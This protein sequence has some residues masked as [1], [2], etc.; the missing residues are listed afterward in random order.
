M[1]YRAR[2]RYS[3]RVSRWVPI[4]L[5]AYLLVGCLHL[6]CYAD[7]GQ[8][9]AHSCCQQEDASDGSCCEKDIALLSQAVELNV[10]GAPLLFVLEPEPGAHQ[11]LVLERLA[12]RAIPPP[13]SAPQL[14]LA[15]PRAPPFQA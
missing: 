8:E 2:L 9:S 14:K 15:P 6:P 13:K 4:F 10:P 3:N 5:L 11:L 7:L 12:P 1:A